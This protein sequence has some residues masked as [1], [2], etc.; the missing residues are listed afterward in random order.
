MA[1]FVESIHTSVVV[2][3]PTSSPEG[4]TSS[5]MQEFVPKSS[6]QFLPPIDQ[7]TGSRLSL[8]EKHVERLL[9]DVLFVVGLDPYDSQM[10]ILHASLDVF[11]APKGFASIHNL[12]VT[13]YP[14]ARDYFR[15]KRACGSM[16]TS[17]VLC[18]R[19]VT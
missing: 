1:L 11:P 6:S 8:V 9:D 16:P 2:T 13:H 18:A 19:W 17:S 7:T 4:P 3:H 5:A 14:L 12:E 10:R 15:C